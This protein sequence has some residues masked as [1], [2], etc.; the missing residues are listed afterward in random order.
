MFHDE[1]YHEPMTAMACERWYLCFGSHGLIDSG[2]FR[3]NFGF[4]VSGFR[5]LALYLE[6]LRFKASR[7]QGSRMF[8]VVPVSSNQYLT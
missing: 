5:D 1:Q 6:G 2:I 8:M 3:V 4:G 7:A